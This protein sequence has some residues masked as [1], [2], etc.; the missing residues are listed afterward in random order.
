[1]RGA[2]VASFAG[3]S[4]SEMLDG[5]AFSSPADLMLEHSDYH[6]P[7][8]NTNVNIDTGRSVRTVNVPFHRVTT[9]TL[10]TLQGQ[11]G[12]TGSLVWHEGTH[13]AKLVG[14]TGMRKHNFQDHWRG[15]MVFKI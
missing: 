4:F 2:A 13:T 11:L 6:I 8:G 14:F 9:S 5:D 15:D 10:T 1:M 12:D 7:G 3:T